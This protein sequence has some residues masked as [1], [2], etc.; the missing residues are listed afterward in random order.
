MATALS[1]GTFAHVRGDPWGC[2]NWL[3]TGADLWGTEAHVVVHEAAQTVV[4][5]R[6]A[7]PP[8][9][10]PSYPAE[11][12]RV[13]VR[14]DRRIFAVPVA[15]DTRPWL[16]RYPRFTLSQI[17]ATPVD[18]LIPWES[19]LG[20]LCLWYPR[21]PGHLQ[22]R[23]TD[24]LDGYLRLVQRHVWSEEYWRRHGDWPAEDVPHG[25]R[26][27]GRP[28]PILTPALRSM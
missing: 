15:A 12:V 17:I 11:H 5:V 3:T 18:Q 19:L 23:W 20:C 27:D 6:F 4:D 7:P 24:G 16:H 14:N 22:W 1:L 9:E 21:D 13:T 2:A 28:H 26:P 25:R 8:P 10:L